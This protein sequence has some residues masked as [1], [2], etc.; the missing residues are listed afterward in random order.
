MAKNDGPSPMMEHYRKTKQNYQ[1]AILFYRLGDFYEMFDDDAIKASRLLDLTLTSKECGKGERAPMCGVPYH[2]ADNYIAKLVSFGEKVAICEQLEDAVKGKLVQRD[3]TKIISAGTVTENNMLDEKQNNY[4]LSVSELNGV[5]AISWADITTGDFYAQNVKDDGSFVELL[6]SIQKISPVEIIATPKIA[7][8]ANNTMAVKRAQIVRFSPYSDWEF[9]VSRAYKTLTA[10]FNVHNLAGFGLEDEKTII[11]CSGALISYLNETQK[12]AIS[13]LNA[14]EIVDDGEFMHL[15]DSAIKNLEIIKN[16][17]DGKR[18]GSLQWVIDKTRTAMGSRRLNNWLLSPLQDVEKIEYRQDGVS[19]LFND[20]LMRNA[21]KDLLTSVKDTERLSGKISNNNITPRDCLQLSTSLS[22][23]PSIIFTLAGTNSQILR[24]IKDNIYDFSDL[25]NLI[26][27]AISQDAPLN[28]K[29]GGY[30]AEGFDKELDRLREVSKNSNDILLEMEERERQETGIKTLKIRYNKVFGYYIEVSNS[31]KDKVPYNYVRKQTLTT[32]ERFIT[33]ELK[34]L[35]EEILSS[36]ETCLKIE[37]E[38]FSKIKSVLDDNLL[39][40]KRSSKAIA[41]L[42]VLL[43][44][45]MVAKANN[46]CRPIVNR[47]SELSLI[48]SRHAV[49]EEILDGQFIANDCFMNDKTDNM[50]IITG[51]NMAG[52]STYMRQIALITIM[53][54]VGSFVPCKS[55][56]IPL[57]DKIFTRVG[58]SDNLISDQ[59]TFMVEMNEVAVIL[60]KATKNSLLILD[61]VGRGTSTFD[62]LSIA[63]AVIEYIVKK[64]GAKTLFATHYHELSELEGKLDGVK[65]YKICVKEENGNIIFLRKIKEG[66]ANKSFGIEVASLAGVPKEVT[67]NARSILKRLEQNDIGKNKK[68]DEVEED[69]TVESVIKEALLSEDLDNFSPRQALEFLYKLKEIAKE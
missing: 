45:A 24:D 1:D 64:I 11:S 40:I 23:F 32:G 31:F 67:L 27:H 62:G 54:H 30:I 36:K 16:M 68:V 51:P 44:F 26:S 6:S 3:V 60:N 8:L 41:T 49:V 20:A 35:E 25:T 14:I 15:N 50:L 22:V 56:K 21:V 66:S 12:R 10:Q 42:D 59:S 69:N 5:Y 34:K 13:N 53:A 7:Q 18:Y 2:A 52:K 48:Q 47:D 28:L 4:I 63:W 17:R 29:D 33:E 65:N 9:S 46:Y 19:E 38:I 55:A 43:S 39:K 57:T 61:E 58:A 37:S